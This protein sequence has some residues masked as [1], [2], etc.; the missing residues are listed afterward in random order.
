VSHDGRESLEAARANVTREFL[1]REGVHGVGLRPLQDAVV[2][3]LDDEPS[4]G[5]PVLQDRL[6]AAAA[7]H[8]VIVVVQPAASMA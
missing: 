4:C 2:V 8:R 3:Y 7:P 6:A 5:L 1:G